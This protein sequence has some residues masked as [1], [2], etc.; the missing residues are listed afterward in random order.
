MVR[1]ELPLAITFI[2][3]MTVILAWFLNIPFLK[4]ANNELMRWNVVVAAFAA[5][6]GV[7]NLM[8]VH[9]RR[10]N[11]KRG[12]WQYSLVL[13]VC[14][15]AFT[16]LGIATGIQSTPYRYVWNNLLQPLNATVF[17]LNAFWISSA[18]YRAFRFRTTEAA[19]LV[20]AG[21]LVMLGRV[22]IGEAMYKG[23]PDVAN[24]IMQIPNTAGMR[25]ITIGGALGA[26]SMCFRVILGLERSQF[27]GMGE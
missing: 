4:T 15:I 5:G 18:A 17:S 26:I 20:L 25:G 6:L 22:G 3:G 24:W 8:L 23:M 16:I 14:L 9:S 12:T 7:A 19:L 13:I 11:Q 27:G 1:K 2:F 10:V 21:M